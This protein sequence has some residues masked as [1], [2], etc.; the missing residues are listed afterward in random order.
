MRNV[1]ALV[2][3]LAAPL[4]SGC[5]YL[6][7]SEHSIGN[8]TAA[9]E[10]A[11]DC[12]IAGIKNAI[13]SDRRVIMDRG[14]D[15]STLLHEAV[16]HNCAEVSK[17]LLSVGA[18]A[19][20]KTVD[21]VTALHM[22]AQ[23]GNVEILDTLLQFRASINSLDRNGWTPADRALRW[24]KLNAVEFLKGRGGVVHSD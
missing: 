19:N 11:D 12:D 6:W 5:G 20:S 1:N 21:G 18:D 17:Y 4:L 15:Y 13:K 9:V 7:A 24:G 14:D 10:A 22:A 8:Y 16:E 3:V 23:R 2:I